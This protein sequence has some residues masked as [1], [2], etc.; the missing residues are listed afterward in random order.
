MGIL[1]LAI[2][3]EE[4]DR[5]LGIAKAVKAGKLSVPDSTEIANQ[6]IDALMND[7]K[8]QL[9]NGVLRGEFAPFSDTPIITFS[10]DDEKKAA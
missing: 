10:M 1:N 6:L 3:F 9:N 4:L 7:V 5:G 8:R 2:N